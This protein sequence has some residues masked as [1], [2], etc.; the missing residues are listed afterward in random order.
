[1]PKTIF[2]TWI[3]HQR[4]RNIAARLDLCLAELTTRERGLKRYAR[5]I[6]ETLRVL[7]TQRPRSVIVQAPSQVLALL[8]LLLRPFFGYRLILDAHNE[9]VEPYLHRS[10]WVLV[11]TRWLLRRADR[12]IVSNRQL[13]NVVSHEGGLPL[14]LPDALPTIPAT[15]R[16]ELTGPRAVV[17]IS[18]YA[19]DEPFAEVIEAARQVGPAA[20]F[21]VTGNA[22][23]C[24]PSLREKIP[25]NMTLTGFLSEH[26]YWSVLASCDA[27]IDLTT[28]DNCLVCGAY[29]AVALGKPVLLSRND[30]SMEVFAGLAEFTDNTAPRIADGLLRLLATADRPTTT[31]R[32]DFERRWTQQAAELQRYLDS[33]P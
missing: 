20:H 13:A 7:R 1:M 29:E 17:V 21:H 11:L 8:V 19:G 32:E 12:V 16:R 15:D 2:L 27:V 18:T 5:L 14:I 24:P 4:T 23:R 3:E 31:Q 25:A 22:A 26:D 28:M 30:A 10:W 9:A 6:P 33:N